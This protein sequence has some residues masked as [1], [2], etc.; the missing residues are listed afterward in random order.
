MVEV[1][2]QEVVRE[3]RADHHFHKL[4]SV[5]EVI[6]H[7]TNSDSVHNRD[8]IANKD[9]HERDWREFFVSRRGWSWRLGTMPF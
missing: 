8:V 2:R 7:H 4:F 9:T 3:R 5:A 6:F 1:E